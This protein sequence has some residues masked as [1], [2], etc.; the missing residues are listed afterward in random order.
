MTKTQSSGTIKI[1]KERGRTRVSESL[2]KISQL[3]RLITCPKG[4]RSLAKVKNLK[5]VKESMDYLIDKGE[6]DESEEDTNK[7]GG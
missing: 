1:L 6:V 2:R 7:S 5:S 3:K 4:R